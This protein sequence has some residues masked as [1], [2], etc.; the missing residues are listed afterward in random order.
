V[1]IQK[2]MRK[3]KKKNIQMNDN[4]MITKESPEKEMIEYGKNCKKCGHCCSYGSGFI[5]DQE[6]KELAKKF[7]LS[8]EEFIGK[9]LEEITKFNTKLHR[10]KLIGKS[11]SKPYGRCVFVKNNRCSIHDIK[12]LHCRIATCDENGESLNEWFIVNYFVNRADPE[13][14]RQWNT[15]LKIRG[16]VQGGDLES[17]VP[18]ESKRKKILN[19]EM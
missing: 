2:R 17:L 12:P 11:K 1:K 13:S 18:D 4:N 3:K 5:H 19:N 7:D 15:R 16:T 14:L 6:V 10:F 9:Y 8:P